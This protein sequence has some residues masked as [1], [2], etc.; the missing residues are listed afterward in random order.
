[1]LASRRLIHICTIQPLRGVYTA[2]A[3]SHVIISVGD[4]RGSAVL[5][6]TCMPGPLR[7]VYMNVNRS[8]YMNVTVYHANTFC[9]GVRLRTYI[10]VI[11]CL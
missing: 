5:I 3:I 6:P 9:A 4:A 7:S 11:F 8:V 10:H 1:V 2:V